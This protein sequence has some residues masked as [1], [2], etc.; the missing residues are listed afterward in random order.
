MRR[1]D[2]IT[3]VGDSAIDSEKAWREAVAKFVPRGGMIEVGL[4]RKG[5]A[6]KVT[7][8]AGAGAPKGKFVT[9]AK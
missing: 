1:G 7:V 4:V 5:E 8:P 3:R 2:I 9:A 6:M